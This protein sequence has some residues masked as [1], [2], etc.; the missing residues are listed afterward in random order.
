MDEVLRHVTNLY[1]EYVSSVFKNN[2]LHT[3]HTIWE[4]C[5][6]YKLQV[7]KR[8]KVFRSLSASV[9]AALGIM[10][11]E[12][13]SRAIVELDEKEQAV[14]SKSH[15]ETQLLSLTKRRDAVFAA[16]TFWFHDNSCLKICVTRVTG[17]IS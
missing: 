8:P 14:E 13:P 7:T 17:L 9:S 10:K 4:N 5:F 3:E 2:A 12:A 1:L 15:P 11:Q 16:R 6:T